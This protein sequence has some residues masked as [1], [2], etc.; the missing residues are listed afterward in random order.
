MVK[1]VGAE[2]VAEHLAADKF[3]IVDPRRP[4]KYLSGHL[5]G[6]INIPMYQ[7]FGA[8]GRLLAPDALAVFIGAAGLG[9]GTTPIVYDSPEGQN[10]AMLAWILE[11]LGR[12]DVL[13]MVAFYEHWK[14]DGREVRYRPVA[15]AARQFTTRVNPSVCITL[16]EMRRAE[17]CKLVDFRSREEFLGEKTI[18][19]D[20]PGHIPGA[21]NLVWRD[22][23]SP[24]E[25][26]LAP[27]DKLGSMLAA[28]GIKRG[29][30]VVAYC[31]SGP[32]AALGYL[33]LTQLGYDVRL[34]DGSYAEWNGVGLPAEK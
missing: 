31:R 25:R 5:P 4:M 22:L 13:V 17:N 32:R 23:A 29:D 27:A 14:A 2:W 24:P 34:F 20:A 7:A 21:V 11:Y 10:A 18:G 6:A 3:A 8:D 19:N 1:L 15:T 16:A 28:A 30:Q 33:A 12:A 26:I 9:D